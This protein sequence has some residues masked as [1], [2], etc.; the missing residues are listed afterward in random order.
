MKAIKARI[1]NG[2]F[3]ID[4]PAHFP[5]GTEV[6]LQIADEGGSDMDEAE[7]AALDASLARGWA[8][9]QAGQLRPAEDLVEKLR[10]P[11]L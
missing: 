7:S 3:V 2:K 11:P 10:A 5:E 1:V 4:T 9:T 8:E 6:D